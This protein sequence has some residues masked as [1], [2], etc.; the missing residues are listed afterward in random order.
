MT[1]LLL[2]WAAA[3]ALLTPF[4]ALVHV[5]GFRWLGVG[6]VEA[7]IGFGYPRLRLRWGDVPITV[8][9]WLL[10]SSIT[11][12]DM[13]AERPEHDVPGKDIAT[14]AR[15]FLALLGVAPFLL[16]LLALSAASLVPLS[17]SAAMPIHM[18]QGALAPLSS[19]QPMIAD[20]LRLAQNEPW[21]ALGRL[22]AVMA[23]WNLLPIPTLPGGHA[24]LNLVIG[25]TE[26]WHKP[27]AIVNSLGALLML[28]IVASWGFA[29]FMFPYGLN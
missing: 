25:R 11:P 26:H 12:K 10:G 29:V 18:L 22:A 27:V 17:D 7:Q 5:A 23:I 20:Y 19:A 3:A 2:L 1:T 9:P 14:I 24:L 4:A 21:Q 6:I 15:P 8:T 13:G 28:V 16:V